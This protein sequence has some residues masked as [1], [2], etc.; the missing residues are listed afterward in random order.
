MNNLGIIL[1]SSLV[2]GLLGAAMAGV[3]G[4]TWL[5]IALAYV[6]A[7]QIGL[8]GAALLAAG[9]RDATDFYTDAD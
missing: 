2:S 6:F 7:G 4:A 9:V 1:L 3:L 8:V 5:W